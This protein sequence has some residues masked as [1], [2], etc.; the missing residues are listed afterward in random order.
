MNVIDFRDSDLDEAT[1]FLESHDYDLSILEWDA[2]AV[3]KQGGLIVGI[4]NYQEV[5]R[6]VEVVTDIQEVARRVCEHFGQNEIVEVDC[7]SPTIQDW[8]E[9]KIKHPFANRCKA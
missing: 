3:V 6:R 8:L 5:P 4:G 7:S 9:Y 2:V 1:K